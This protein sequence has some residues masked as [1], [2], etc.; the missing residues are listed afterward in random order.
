MIKPDSG[1]RKRK[2]SANTAVTLCRSSV[3]RCRGLRG[4][5][6]K[7]SL[8]MRRCVATPETTPT[9]MAMAASPTSHLPRSSHF[10]CR[11]W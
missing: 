10:R 6:V 11:L 1:T 2:G 3:L 8:K 9:S 5:K 7:K 4:R